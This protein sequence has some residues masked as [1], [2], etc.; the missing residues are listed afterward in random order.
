[1][2]TI[3][4]WLSCKNSADLMHL[5]QMPFLHGCLKLTANLL[6]FFI[7][8]L[9]LAKPS[10]V[11]PHNSYTA[12]IGTN[13]SLA[14]VVS[15]TT[16]DPP[17]LSVDW[18]KATPSGTGVINVSGSP[19][20]SGSTTASPSLFI[21]NLDIHD[22]GNYSCLATNAAGTSESDPMVLTVTGSE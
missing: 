19:K 16:T 11:A 21:Q 7:T 20:Y 13:V 3:F 12:V 9:Q 8:F 18:K 15:V 6:N 10:V 4:H 14:C 17:V 5:F 22:N 2:L 1:M